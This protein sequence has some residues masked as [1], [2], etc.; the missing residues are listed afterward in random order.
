MR[1]TTRTALLVAGAM[2]CSPLA[3]QD[4]G[5]GG[6]GVDEDTSLPRCGAPY[7][8]AALVEEGKPE[9]AAQ[10]DGNLGALLR[11]AEAQNGGGTAR[12]DPLPLIKL[13]AANSNCFQ[14]VERGQASEALQRERALAGIET[15][16]AT[17]DY[18]LSAQVVYSDSKARKSGGLLGGVGRALG[19]GLGGLVGSAV[20][21]NSKTAEAEV[22]LSLIDV[23]TGVQVAIASGSARKKDIG[24]FGGGLLGGVG[25]GGLGG[26]Y[27]STDIGK[28]TAI[29]TL[30][31]YIN[32]LE[33]G[34][35]T[36]AQNLAQRTEAARIADEKAE[37]H[38]QDAEAEKVKLDD[39]VSGGDESGD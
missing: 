21:F 20:S 18:L 13:M 33:R 8:L 38:G 2:L 27:A 26:T 11:L 23:K 6:T 14:V 10:P 34:E 36:L 1:K 39:S 24:L 7:G 32:L 25:L 35:A 29:A 16:Q 15:K 19:G 30:D 5:K 4:R 12:V 9:Q 37:A 22:L 31:A 17:A 28:V 3:A